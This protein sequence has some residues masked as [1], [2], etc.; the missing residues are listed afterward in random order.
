M[1]GAN[2]Q[3]DTDKRDL[4]AKASKLEVENG[5]LRKAFKALLKYVSVLIVLDIV[6]CIL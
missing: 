2:E 5:E 3:S 1:D 4:A 6:V